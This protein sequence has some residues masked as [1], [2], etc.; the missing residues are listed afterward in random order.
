MLRLWKRPLP[1]VLKTEIMDRIGAS[2]TWVYHAYNNA[3]VDVEGKQ[4]KSV[5][6]GTRWG[7]G[8]WISTRDQARFGLLISRKGEWGGTRIISESWIDAATRQQG[9]SEGYG[10]LWWLNNKGAWPDAPA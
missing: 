8:L 7:G 3:T 6:G 1:E 2:E 9:K 5:S 10:Y 4:M